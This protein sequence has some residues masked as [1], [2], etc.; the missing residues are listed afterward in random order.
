MVVDDAST[1]AS[2]AAPLSQ[3]TEPA[4]CTFCHWSYRV[5]TLGD[6]WEARC[7]RCDQLL[8]T[9]A[10]AAEQ[11]NFAAFMFTVLTIL[12]LP[13]AFTWPLFS[14]QSARQ[15]YEAGFITVVTTLYEKAE[16]LLASLITV[17][18]GIFPV[19]KLLMMLVITS[20]MILNLR[21]IRWMYNIAHG[22]RVISLLDVILSALAIF[23]FLF[24][25][26]FD[27]TAERGMLAFTAMVFCNL[28]ATLLFNSLE[29]RLEDKNGN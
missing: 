22:A 20:S 21:V 26:R 25:R 23:V 29:F 4:Y 6:G 10:A 18:S 8:P 12:I 3:A 28:T 17:F 5:K 9:D 15:P 14:V 1:T 27:I 2:T 13:F 11:K 16:Y 24:D 7:P 19:I